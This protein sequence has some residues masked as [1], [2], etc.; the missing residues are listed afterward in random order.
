MDTLSPTINGPGNVPPARTVLRKNPSGAISE[1]TIFKVATGP[2]E[3]ETL[4][5]TPSASKKAL[6]KLIEEGMQAKNHVALPS[7]LF[8]FY[9]ALRS[10]FPSLNVSTI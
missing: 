3:A 6:K 7:N 5:A 9:G 2:I 8:R 1:F 4:E 10:Q